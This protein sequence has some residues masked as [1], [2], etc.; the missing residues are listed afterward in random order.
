MTE[1]Q[2]HV[3]GLQ[4]NLESLRKVQSTLMGESPSRSGRPLE[5]E[6]PGRSSDQA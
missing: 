5:L 4:K 3:I 2:D 6:R 1:M